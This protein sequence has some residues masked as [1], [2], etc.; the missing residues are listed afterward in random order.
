MS[1]FALPRS[2]PDANR[3]AL[4]GEFEVWVQDNL[5]IDLQFVEESDQPVR[6]ESCVPAVHKFGDVRLFKAEPSGGL[7]LSQPQFPNPI[8]NLAGQLGFE[9]QIFGVPQAQVGENVAAPIVNRNLVPRHFGF[10]F[11]S[12]PHFRLAL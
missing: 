2:L 10:H 12:F 7:H 3:A 11:W 4:A 1:V 8:T 9:T 5:H 6:R